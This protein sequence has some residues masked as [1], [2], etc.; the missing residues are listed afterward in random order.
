MLI[1]L[2]T[3]QSVA[4]QNQGSATRTSPDNSTEGNKRV[5]HLVPTFGIVRAD[6]KFQPLAP[7]DKLKLGATHA[8]DRITLVKS[9]LSAAISQA[10]DAP[11]GYGQGWDGYGKR[12]GAAAGNIGTNELFSTFLFPSVLHQDPR[13]FL[14]GAGTSKQRVWYAIS[15][16][17]KTRTDSGGTAFNTAKIL[18]TFFSAAAT[19]AYYP[20]QDRTYGGTI[21]RGG[22]RLAISAGTNVLQ[23]FSLEIGKLFR[24]RKQ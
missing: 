17:W 9:A 14:S 3:I 16:V 18:G 11:A 1:C 2:L 13:Y 10:S 5:F 12:V 19:N 15:R 4:G 23:E 20:D 8:F 22:I 24:K 7:G 6:A 21:K